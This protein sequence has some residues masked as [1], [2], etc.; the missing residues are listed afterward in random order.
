MSDNWNDI[1]RLELGPADKKQGVDAPATVSGDAAGEAPLAFGKGGSSSPK[2][3]KK[4]HG[5]FRT[6]FKI[7][8]AL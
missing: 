8:F 6:F 5:L 2:H 4:K 1:E 7:V 3:V